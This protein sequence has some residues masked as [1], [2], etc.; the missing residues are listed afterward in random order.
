MFPAAGHLCQLPRQE[1]RLLHRRK[2]GTMGIG[3]VKPQKKT[4]NKF[5]KI[6]VLARNEHLQKVRKNQSC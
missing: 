5:L 3:T 2:R 6:T 4:T 1:N